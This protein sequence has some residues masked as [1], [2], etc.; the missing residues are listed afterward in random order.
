MSG[1]TFR[2]IEL[3]PGGKEGGEVREGELLRLPMGRSRPPAIQLPH[4]RPYMYQREQSAES[5]EALKLANRTRRICVRSTKE[6]LWIKPPGV[7]TH[8]RDGTSSSVRTRSQSTRN[9][10]VA[11]ERVERYP[12]LGVRP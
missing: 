6:S 12:R 2:G 7:H 4:G 3:R 1:E 8:V 11:V 10:V 5:R 9:K